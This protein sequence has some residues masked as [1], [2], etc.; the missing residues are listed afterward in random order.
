MKELV[1]S[2]KSSSEMMKDF[3]RLLRRLANAK[4]KSL[5]MK[6]LLI[7]EKILRSSLDTFLSYLTFSLLS[8]SPSMSWHSSQGL[9]SPT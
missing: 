1:I 6:S 5:I 3:K 8:Q 2:L 7:T 9:M 4:L